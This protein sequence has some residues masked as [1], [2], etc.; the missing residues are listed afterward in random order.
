M[1]K[2]FLLAIAAFAIIPLFAQEEIPVWKKLRYLSEEE[3]YLEVRSPR[4]FVET[5]PPEGEIRN[6]AE[7]DPMQAVLVRYPFGVP[8]TVL[9]EIAEDLELVVICED[10]GEEAEVRT[11]FENYGVNLDH[12]NFLYART[13]SWWVRDY[14]PWFV[15]DGNNR[16]GIV[17][18][19]YNRPRPRDNDIPAA[20][21]EYLNIDLYGMNILHTGGN[22]MTDGLGKSSSTDLIEEEN[23]GMTTDE[24]NGK[25]RDYL[26]IEDYYILKDPLDDYIKHIDCWGKFLTPHKVIIG[27]VDETDYR[28]PD[29]EEVADFFSTTNSSYGVPYEVY[30]VYTPGKNDVTPYTNSLIVNEKVFVPLS[31][32]SWDDEA[33]AVYEE[34]LPGYEIIGIYHW[35]WYNTD[36]L[37]CRTKGIADLGMLYVDHIPVL[38]EQEF[39]PQVE[40]VADITAYSGMPIYPDSVTMFYTLNDEEALYQSPFNL[41]ADGRWHTTVSGLQPGDEVAY[42]MEAKDASGRTSMHPFIGAADPH[43]FQLKSIYP[44]LTVNPDTLMFDNYEK[45]TSGLTAT[46]SNNLPSA[47]NISGFDLPLDQDFT[48]GLANIPSLPYM[49][50]ANGEMSFTLYFNEPL[51]EMGTFHT[52]SVVVETEYFDY[53]VVFTIDRTGVNTFETGEETYIRVFPNPA[54][55]EVR[56]L[57]QSGI[58]GSADLD[59]FNANGQQVCQ[60]T[61]KMAPGTQR[62][63]WDL[64]DKAGRRVSPGLYYYQIVGDGW[65]LMG[66]IVIE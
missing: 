10:A 19:P 44:E 15:F 63:V 29:F 2:L 58:A 42:Y 34:A 43:L 24:I 36:A 1:K 16:P 20:V 8:V 12:C 46:V 50:E 40:F 32:S 54:H 3:M 31:G 49:L 35:G 66:E 38:G 5:D 55:H 65:N 28:Y 39:A 51:P 33:L 48:M 57:F 11:T 52:D 26:A 7:F 22:Y 61:I 53:P 59:I 23:P 6:V 47:V 30:R 37:H 9:K 27:Q 13:N 56:F 64:N 41:E 18:F 17:D 21:A 14:G 60:Q 25:L 62:W 4:E 45:L